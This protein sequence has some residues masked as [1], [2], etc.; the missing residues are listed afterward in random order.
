MVA[1]QKPEIQDMDS[2]KSNAINVWWASVVLT[3]RATADLIE[4]L[5]TPVVE[6]PQE[7][8]EPTSPFLRR[9]P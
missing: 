7:P 6:E 3:L 9:E 5:H 1:V 2:P 8:E 4:Y